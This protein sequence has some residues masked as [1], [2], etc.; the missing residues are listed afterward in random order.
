V[1]DTFRMVQGLQKKGILNRYMDF[2]QKSD[3]DGLDQFLGQCNIR[4]DDYIPW[5]L[6][7]MDTG[8]AFERINNSKTAGTLKG[9]DCFIKDAYQMPYIPGSSLK[10]VLRTALLVH[11]IIRANSSEYDQLKA[12]LDRAL[13]P[14]DGKPRRTVYLKAETKRL[15]QFFLHKDTKEGEPRKQ[16][17]VNSYLAGLIVSDSEPIPLEQLTLS[18][19]IDLTM[20]R[21][22]KGLPI[23]REALKPGTVVRTTISMD[24]TRCPYTMEEIQTALNEWNDVVYR[25]FYSKF[26][27]GN[28]ADKTIWLGGGV[29][30]PTK[31][32]WGAMFGTDYVDK[33]D[34]VF[35]NTLLMGKRDMYREH[36][37]DQ[38]RR[39]GVSPHTCK[40]TRYEGKTYDMGM[41]KLEVL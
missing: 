34:Q 14:R 27:R 12:E 2:M 28:Q 11:E 39:M 31:T 38:D 3:I 41:A 24:G 37:H 29:G 5:I 32:L 33:A 36:K 23:L 8:D 19:K 9:I 25:L 40:C 15:E 18:Q 16:D 20:K 22:E 13:R 26:G 7:S 17:A 35:R 1:P 10:G 4:Q 21:E 30:F 6:Y